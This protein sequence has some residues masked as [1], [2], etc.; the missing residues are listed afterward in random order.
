MG[1]N[2]KALEEYIKKLMEIQFSTSSEMKLSDD[3]LKE[4][5]LD[6]GMSEREYEES[7]SRALEYK[8]RGIAF[9]DEE[10][11]DDALT[12]LEH[13]SAL[14]P[15]DTEALN[16][17]AKALIA[18]GQRTDEESYFGRAENMLK[19]VFGIDPNNKDAISI[20]KSL[21]NESR[22][23]KVETDIKQRKSKLTK[24]LVIGGV[25]VILL[26]GYYT[27]RNSLVDKEESV[28]ASWA[29]VENVYQ[30]RANLIPNLVETVKGVAKIE[31]ETLESLTEA[32]AEVSSLKLDPS[33]LTE[34]QL[35]MFAEKQS[36]LSGALGRLIA[37]VEA[38][39]DLKFPENFRGLQDELAGTE[40]RIAIERRN[41]NK[42]VKDFNAYSR[43][44]PN[45][46]IGFGEKPYFQAE[47]G[48]EKAPDVKF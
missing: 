11:W 35:K 48:A 24:W 32:R 19:R 46:M 31:R 41:F 42:V 20:S 21:R 4:I 8:S 5:A 30:R 16:S 29:Q 34:A 7:R 17:Y 39:P 18:I 43:K 44:F 22:L 47:E 2:D 10:N 37:V 36:A 40:N 1:N 25:A 45:N 9:A 6:I 28:N 14:L 23:S 26:F 3:K 27:K 33:D 15:N 12:Q 13:A 38:Y